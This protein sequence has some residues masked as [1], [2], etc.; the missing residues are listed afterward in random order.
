[1]KVLIIKSTHADAPLAEIRTDLRLIDWITDSTD[2]ALPEATQNSYQRL[3]SI[4]NSSSHL[5]ME[6]PKMPVAHLLRYVLD[7]GDVAEITTDG[8]TCLLN[9]KLLTLEHKNALFAAIARKE[10]NVTR[11][12]DI[13]RPIPVMPAQAPKQQPQRKSSHKPGVEAAISAELKK[14]AK[15][16][17]SSTIDY[18]HK[19]ENMN[20]SH[21]SDY[22]EREK[23]KEL[24]YA[25]KYG[26]A[27][28]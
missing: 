28:R 27:R 1:M 4:I 19:I 23:V 18:D 13:T 26:K 10:V 8:K 20:L 6:E 22:Q 12:A 16:H 14:Q 17:A 7:N 21:I 3:V 25:L 2:G 11:K 5:S 24:A 15:L 9:G